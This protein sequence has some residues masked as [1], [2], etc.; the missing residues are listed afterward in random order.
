MYA[1]GDGFE[2]DV[3]GTQDDV[4]DVE[5]EDQQDEDDNADDDQH[6]GNVAGQLAYVFP[7]LVGHSGA[8][9]KDV[10]KVI[11]ITDRICRRT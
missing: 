6:G 2:H 3:D 9:F 1:H 7:F 4:C 8:V 5:G 11:K 10:A